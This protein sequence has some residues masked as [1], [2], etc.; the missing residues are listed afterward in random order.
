[1]KTIPTTQT[2]SSTLS[3]RRSMFNVL[4]TLPLLLASTGSAFAATGY[5]DASSAN[6]TPPYTNWATAA[7]T[8]QDA[9]DAAAVGDEIVVTNG[10]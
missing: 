3:V 1:M 6:P 5:L 8:I 2:P 10:L 7:V 9:V 4:L